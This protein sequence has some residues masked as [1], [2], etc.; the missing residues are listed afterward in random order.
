MRL[1]RQRERKL[2]CPS[3]TDHRAD[4]VAARIT[5][6]TQVVGDTSADMRAPPSVATIIQNADIP[7]VASVTHLHAA[8]AAASGKARKG[9]SGTRKRGPGVS[10]PNG[11]QYAAL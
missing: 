9:S 8:K 5:S 10:P 7:A 11:I 4:Q 1:C 6:E 3:A 2:R